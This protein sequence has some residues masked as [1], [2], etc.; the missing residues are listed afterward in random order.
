M[1]VPPGRL[2][3][4]P[5]PV[6][7]F[8]APPIDVTPYQPEDLLGLMDRVRE[9]IASRFADPRPESDAVPQETR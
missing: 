8:V 3:V 5:G 7:V 9:I 1:V 2:R 4:T 6:E